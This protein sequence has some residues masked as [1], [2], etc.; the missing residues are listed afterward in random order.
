MRKF[1][2]SHARARSEQKSNITW[3][4]L[5]VSPRLPLTVE[6]PGAVATWGNLDRNVCW[7]GVFKHTQV[8]A[9]PCASYLQEDTPVFWCVFFPSPFI[10]L[11]TCSRRGRRCLV[12]VCEAAC[13]SGKSA[14]LPVVSVHGGARGM[15]HALYS[16]V[17]G[18]RV[19]DRVLPSGIL[20]NHFPTSVL[21]PN[22]PQYICRGQ[23][24]GP[25]TSHSPL[26]PHATTSLAPEYQKL[27]LMHHNNLWNN[28]GY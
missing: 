7:S 22:V 11:Q 13:R 21:L 14:L 2:D 28:T 27:L 26:E 10:L 9:C 3:W 18:E 16:N 12:S 20:V 15:P 4:Y 6:E 24:R 25:V 17:W 1:L 8:R 5:T 19:I 23:Q